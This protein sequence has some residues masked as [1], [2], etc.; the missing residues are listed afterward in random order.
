V[1]ARYRRTL[2]EATDWENSIAGVTARLNALF[3]T[4]QQLLKRIEALEDML[5]RQKGPS[6]PQKPPKKTFH[7]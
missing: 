5:Q 4:Q 6:W 3:K 2:T 7:D 1:K